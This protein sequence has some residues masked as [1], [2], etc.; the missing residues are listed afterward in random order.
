MRLQGRVAIVTGG[1]GGMGRGICSCLAREG[2]DLVISDLDLNAAE[3]VASEGRKGGGRAL[4][5]K[6]DVTSEADCRAL[7]DRAL[8]EFGRIDILVN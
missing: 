2:A 8:E 3:R 5:V 7:I 1:G 4:S 6:S